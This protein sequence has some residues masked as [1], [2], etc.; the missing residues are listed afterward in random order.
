MIHRVKPVGKAAR[1]EESLLFFPVL[2][3]GGLDVRGLLFGF[4]SQAGW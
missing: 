1:G 4:S 3:G 2:D